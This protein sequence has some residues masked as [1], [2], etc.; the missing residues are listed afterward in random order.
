MVAAFTARER[1][2]LVVQR[3]LPQLGGHLVATGS[4]Q[5][6]YDGGANQLHSQELVRRAACTSACTRRA[7]QPKSSWVE[8]AGVNQCPAFVHITAVCMQYASV[9]CIWVVCH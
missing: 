3:V 6:H 4:Q 7:G 1:E 2:M 5:P 8:F 9:S